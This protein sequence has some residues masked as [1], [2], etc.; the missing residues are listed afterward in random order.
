MSHQVYHIEAAQCGLPILYLE[1]G[2]ITEYCEGYGLSFTEDNLEE[3]YM[4]L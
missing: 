1:S 4:K 2:G 3:K